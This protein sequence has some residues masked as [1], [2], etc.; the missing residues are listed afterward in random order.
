MKEKILTALT[1]T[2]TELLNNPNDEIKLAL[3][4]PKDNSHGDFSTN[5]AMIIA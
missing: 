1:E 3:T 4:D 5:A 2:V